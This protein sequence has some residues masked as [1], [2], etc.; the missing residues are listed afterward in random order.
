MSGRS[1][2]RPGIPACVLVCTIVLASVTVQRLGA[3][4]Y[5]RGQNVAAA[6][7]GW[8]Q[9]PDGS[10]DLV[11]GYMNRNW[12]EEL[13]APVG[14]EN[15]LDPGG[16]DQGQPTHF[17]PRRNRFVF[18]VRV[19]QD[20]GDQEL[21]W[22]LTTNGKTE[23]AYGTLKPDYFL[24]D[25]VI[26]MN[27]SRAV[28]DSKLFSSNKAPLLDVEG[29]R[30]RTTAVGQPVT[31]TALASDDDL[32]GRRNLP[33]VDP[34]RPAGIAQASATGLRLAWFVYRGAGTVTFDPPQFKVYEDTRRGSSPWAPGWVAPE[35]PPEGKWVVRA[36]FS[37]P[38]TYVLRC[39]AHDGGLTTYE[40]ITVTVN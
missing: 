17:L 36:T 14:P 34:R 3:Q 26:T 10:F 30:A 29:D 21:V 25:S 33:P 16:P 23:R 2:L 4:V 5:S 1:R 39:L 37:E 9:N 32:P 18:R 20:F 19:P 13:D 7:E 8:L 35:V 38:G 40:D 6:Y 22:T 28:G 12:E 24:D 31:L 15:N 11:F 27:F